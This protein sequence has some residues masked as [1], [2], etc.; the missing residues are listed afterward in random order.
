MI[1]SGLHGMPVRTSDKKGVCLSDACI[2]TK[3][4]KD[5][6]IFLYRTKDHLVYISEKKN[7]WW[8]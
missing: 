5:L 8:G 2:V 1:F 4:K 6:S 3:C 7:G